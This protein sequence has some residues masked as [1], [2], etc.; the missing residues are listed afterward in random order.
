[1]STGEWRDAERAL[2]HEMMTISA[3]ESTVAD[4]RMAELKAR[5]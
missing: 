5:T 3:A 1:V 4:A 2:L